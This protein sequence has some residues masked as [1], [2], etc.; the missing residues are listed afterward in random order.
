MRTESDFH[1][2]TNRG[3]TQ[4][5]KLT[6]LNSGALSAFLGKQEMAW[7][8]GLLRLREGNNRSRLQGPCDESILL[9]LR[10]VMEMMLHPWIVLNI[11]TSIGKQS[12]HLE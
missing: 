11:H 12:F 7:L 1:E 4:V 9:R 5:R 3:F 2:T 8:A 6:Q 10:V